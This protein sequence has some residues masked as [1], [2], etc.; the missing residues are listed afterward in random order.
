MLSSGIQVMARAAQEAWWKIATKKAVET[1]AKIAS[2]EAAKKV[3]Q[4]ATR[5]ATSEAAKKAAEIAAEHGAH[6]VFGNMRKGLTLKKRLKTLEKM[7]K[8]GELRHE[9]YKTLRKQ[10]LEETGAGDL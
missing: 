3:A 7:L 6:K 10:V 2:S 5:I 4:T 8:K 1:A 9:E